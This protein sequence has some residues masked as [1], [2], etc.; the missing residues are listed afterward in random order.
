MG[1]LD[2]KA[3][4]VTGAASGLGQATAILAA[5]EGSK[6]TVADVNEDGGRETVEQIRSLGGEA[7]FVRTDVTQAEDVR[8]MVARTVATFGRI[9][10]AS[11]NAV[12]GK[13]GFRPLHEI[14][15]EGGSSTIDVCLKGVF[16]GMKYEIKAM[17][18]SGGGSIINI[19]TA[20]IFKGEA[21]LA[22][23]VAAKGGV[24]TLTKTGAAEYATRGIRVNSVAPGGFETPALAGYLKQFPEV[25]ERVAATHAMRRFGKPEEVAEPVIW[26]ASDRSSFVTGT[27][28]LCDGGVLVNSHM[29]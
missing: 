28:I 4:L 17:L 1:L 23:Y 19:S 8:E 20:S 13:G 15:E 24:D 26:L 16:Y 14:D 29:L 7:V 11:N 27:C 5:R 18:E 22:A 10:W 12:G 21:M 6:V 3:G 2:G 25:R 9:D